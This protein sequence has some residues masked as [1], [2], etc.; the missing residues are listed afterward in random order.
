MLNLKNLFSEAEDKKVEIF[1]YF[2]KKIAFQ[3]FQ[4]FDWKEVFTKAKK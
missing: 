2:E 1:A 4:L 3:Y